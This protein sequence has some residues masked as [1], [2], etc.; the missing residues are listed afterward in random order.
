MPLWKSW[1][2]LSAKV[3]MFQVLSCYWEHRRMSV[4]T[5]W[6]PLSGYALMLMLLLTVPGYLVLRIIGFR[7]FLSVAT[8]PP[9]SLGVM[10]AVGLVLGALDV[11]F[12]LMSL[13][14][15]TVVV[16]LAVALIARVVLGRL[17]A[18][19]PVALISPPPGATGLTLAACLVTALLTALP[20]VDQ[21][22][23][24][25]PA[26]QIDSVFHYNLAWT[27][28]QT[29][30]ASLLTGA[31]WSF[32]LRAIPA[33]YPLMWHALVAAVAG[34]D[35]IVEVTN[36]LVV[37][38]PLIWVLGI[39]GLAR[40]AFPRSRWAPTVA[41]LTTALLPS[42]PVFM[43]AYRQLWPNAL[44]Y[45]VLPATLA[46][47]CRAVRLLRMTGEAGRRRALLG[48]LAFL[49]SL[50][51][52]VSTYPTALVS[53]LLTGLPLLVTIVGVVHRFVWRR[54]GAR[55]RILLLASACLIVLGI[56]AL[57]AAEPNLMARLARPNYA[58]VTNL[59][60]RLRSMVTLW[61][62]GSGGAGMVLT[63]LVQVLVIC[64][65]LVI[66]CREREQRWIAWAWGLPMM[67]LVAAYLPLGPLTALT[68][69][70]YNDPYRIIPL[71]IPAIALM[72]AACV[73]KALQRVEGRAGHE[74]N[75]SI[76]G[77]TLRVRL[78]RPREVVAVCC[79]LVLLAAG[80]GASPGRYDV[81]GSSYNPHSL[82]LVRILN[83][84][85]AEMIT[86]LR[87]RTDPT[88][89]VLGDPAAGAAYAQVMAGLRSVF[90][91]MTYRPLDTDALLL[92]E[93]FVDL[94]T[95][96]RICEVVRHYRIGYYYAAP[97]GTVPGIDVEERSPGLYNVDTS[98]GFELVASSG[99]ASVYRI[100]AC[101]EFNQDRDWWVLKAPFEP[102][103]DE[104]G[105]RNDF[106]A[107]GNC[108]S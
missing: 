71:I 107:E 22:D 56:V 6:A 66:T 77:R 75:W 51:G 14:A 41:A 9:L 73:E 2:G 19:P 38:V 99:E 98:T 35:H 101:G 37:L 24:A 25:L 57:A 93:H 105:H 60:N 96:P 68:G 87:G 76:G 34:P 32:S 54:V 103:F 12:N 80:L 49:A 100:T 15:G 64:A 52:A 28:T 1:G 92:A 108:I 45:A 27:I 31:S 4:L 42:Y 63:Q 79:A 83:T 62:F 11:H 85:E 86:S 20:I 97:A 91:H 46:L 59:F 81:S 74:V 43:L 89:M 106:D 29:G 88:L 70:W 36:V 47:L 82:V 8:A 50:A 102:I 84:E 21:W 10:A 69:L 78:R 67:L 33:Y 58:G 48:L 65:G 7:G 53:I 16:L 39:A 104:E 23:P 94:D 90:P 3:T 72:A 13:M 18:S 17:T 95:D 40:E 5:A 61:P 26:Q 30:D 55:T 44:G